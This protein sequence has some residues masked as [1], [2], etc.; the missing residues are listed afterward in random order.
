MV[1]GSRL[2]PLDRFFVVNKGK[3]RAERLA[4]AASLAILAGGVWFWTMQIMEVLEV[5]SLA[6]G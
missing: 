2:W 4:L 3:R 5:L 6:Y 1:Y